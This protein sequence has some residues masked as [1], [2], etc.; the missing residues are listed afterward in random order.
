MNF[1]TTGLLIYEYDLNLK[2]KLLVLP[3]TTQG[4]LIW[5]K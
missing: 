3:E 5:G 1:I 2:C 4:D